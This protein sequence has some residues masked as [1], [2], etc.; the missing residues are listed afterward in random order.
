[1]EYIY[2]YIFFAFQIERQIKVTSDETVQV[3]TDL[4]VNFKIRDAFC[5]CT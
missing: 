1:M 2:I 4:E 5:K 3:K